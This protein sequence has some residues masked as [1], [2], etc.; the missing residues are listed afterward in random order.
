MC[1]DFWTAATRG[2]VAAALA[3]STAVVSAE[4]IVSVSVTDGHGRPVAGLKL[5]SFRLQSNGSDLTV[6]AFSGPES[7]ISLA[8]VS[9]ESLPEA[10][11]LAQPGDELVQAPSLDEAVRRL[12]N[13]EHFRRTIILTEPSSL[14][15][16]PADIRVVHASRDDLP[17][18]AGALR[19][20]YL[21]SFDAP[22]GADV[23]V[24]LRRTFLL[25]RLEVS[26]KRS[27]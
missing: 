5:D 23:T 8:V 27:L 2:F 17:A 7:P 15:T 22:E 10:A 18:L 12:A 6:S 19:R 26:W 1:T 24:S 25:P 13:A 14:R 20:D 3:C 16:V 11:G 9:P 21:M 4:E